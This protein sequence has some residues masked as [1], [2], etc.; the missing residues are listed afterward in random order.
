VTD[1]RDSSPVVSTK[2]TTFAMGHQT[3]YDSWR[4]SGR[5]PRAGHLTRRVSA[6]SVSPISWSKRGESAPPLPAAGTA[7]ESIAITVDFDGWGYVHLYSYPGMLELDTYAIP[8]AHDVTKAFGFGDLSVHEVEMS[9]V[10]NTLAY[11]S[12]Y[13]GGFRVARIQPS[14]GGFALNE[15]G[16]FIDA[17]GDG[18][19]NFWGVQVWQ[20]GGQE[21][22][23]ASDRDFGIYIFK[24]IGP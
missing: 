1:F 19:N 9:A 7:G 14:N 2:P 10:D 11:F 4:K 3:R 22:V 21:Y 5:W 15:V 8:E 13:S 6:R 16:R 20:H 18:G 12:Y 24:Y 17:G 23:L